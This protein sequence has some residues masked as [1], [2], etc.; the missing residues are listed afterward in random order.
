MKA[1]PLPRSA[2]GVCLADGKLSS[3]AVDFG[4]GKLF[5]ICGACFAA[6]FGKRPVAALER[7]SARSSSAEASDV[8]KSWMEYLGAVEAAKRLGGSFE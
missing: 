7:L 5:E 1:H 3:Y 8:F 2:N 4:G 6:V